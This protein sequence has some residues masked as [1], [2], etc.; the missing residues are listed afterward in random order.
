MAGSHRS[1]LLAIASCRANAPYAGPYACPTQGMG[2][3]RCYGKQNGQ[4]GAWGGL[5]GVWH[6]GEGAAGF[7]SA[8]FPPVV[9]GG[10]AGCPLWCVI[11]L[12]VQVCMGM[13]RG[14]EG[15]RL[16]RCQTKG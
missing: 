15:R 10:L 8:C 12:D 11:P 14:A 1:F 4:Q 3:Q 6:H 9:R 2:L 16:L 13:L 7:Q 5:S